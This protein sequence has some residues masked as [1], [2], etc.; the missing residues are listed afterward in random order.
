MQVV[1]LR[2]CC[3]WRGRFDALDFEIQTVAD[4]ASMTPRSASRA[5]GRTDA[6][7]PADLIPMWPILTWVNKPENGDP[8]I[9]EP[10]ALE[11][12]HWTGATASSQSRITF[13][14]GAAAPR[15][16][17]NVNCI[18]PYRRHT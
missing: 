7:F 5:F 17:N 10:I 15:P 12:P 6:T 9:V 2:A 18:L 14:A 13:A 4:L 1:L 8:S 3:C 11:S 16:Q